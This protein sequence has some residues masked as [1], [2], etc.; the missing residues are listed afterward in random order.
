MIVI[1]VIGID[2]VDFDMCVLCGIVVSYICGYV[3]CMVFEYMFVLIFVL[4]CSFVVYC[5]VVCVG[6]WFDS[7]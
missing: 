3:V 5:D 1:V 4:C 6:C 7:G 2:I